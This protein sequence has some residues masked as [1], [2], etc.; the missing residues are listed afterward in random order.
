MINR[1]SAASGL[2]C[3]VLLSSALLAAG[4]GIPRGGGR[5]APGA[6]A[7]VDLPI[8]ECPK[9]SKKIDAPADAPPTKCPHCSAKIKATK[10]DGGYDLQWIETEENPYK[11][12]LIIGGAVLAVLG[13]IGMILKRTLF[14]APPPK[15][16]KKQR[17]ER[18]DDEDDEEDDE[19]DRPRRKPRRRDI[20]D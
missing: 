15:K 20:D 1:Q 9:C 12:P 8:F 7:Q 19:D 6:A 2:A 10:V 11:K 18:D 5:P 3:A 17:R 16:K 4:Q 14:A 13:I